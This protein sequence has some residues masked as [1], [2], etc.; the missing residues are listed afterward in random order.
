M[1]SG[2]FNAAG[3]FFGIAGSFTKFDVLMSSSNSYTSGFLMG[4]EPSLSSITIINPF[5]HE[6]FQNNGYFTALS[7]TQTNPSDIS[8]TF[9][10]LTVTK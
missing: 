10:A 5:D 7:I 1:S 3:D 4:S 8:F 2:R 9:A 6:S